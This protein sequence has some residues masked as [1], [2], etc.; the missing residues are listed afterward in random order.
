MK[1]PGKSKQ[2]NPKSITIEESA[3]PGT[4]DD[5]ED[6]DLVMEQKKAARPL[7]FTSE[8]IEEIMKIMGKTHSSETT[9][10]ATTTISKKS[11]SKWAIEGLDLS[12]SGFSKLHS[13][14]SK[15][16]G[17]KLY[18][19][20][21]ETF[22]SVRNLCNQKV[23]KI[24]A[25]E[26]FTVSNGIEENYEVMNVITQYPNIKEREVEE[27]RDI[28]WPS[29]DPYF[30]NQSDADKFTDNQIKASV[31]GSY[32]HS[33]LTEAAQCKLQA[34]KAFYTVTVSSGGEYIDGPSFYLK[35]ARIVDPNNMHL[36]ET[37]RS[38]IKKMDVK[39]YGYSA[40]AMLTEFKDEDFQ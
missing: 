20:D 40:K 6:P 25:T 32:L 36:I 8:Q 22:L 9:A 29:T 34:D 13:K 37:M 10:P 21:Q 24:H 27:F 39:D 19:L 16:D 3:K 14:E 33:M 18:D 15:F 4:I 17:D 26:I 2:K 11:L 23:K 28:R 38:K 1:T 7:T 5:D 31:F 30:H 12:D 35:V